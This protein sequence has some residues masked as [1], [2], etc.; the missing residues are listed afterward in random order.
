MVGV[1][2]L[3]IDDNVAS[4][5][6]DKV[7]PVNVMFLFN[8][9]LTHNTVINLRLQHDLIAASANYHMRTRKKENFLYANSTNNTSILFLVDLLINLCIWA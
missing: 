7:A 4:F 3:I 9:S 5:L 8:E 6:L 1:G 2:L